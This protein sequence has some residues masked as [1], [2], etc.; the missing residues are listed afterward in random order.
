[1]AIKLSESLSEL[2]MTLVVI[3]VAV[4]GGHVVRAA[5]SLDTRTRDKLPVLLLVRYRV[6]GNASPVY[7]SLKPCVLVTRVVDCPSGAI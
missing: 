1:M 5:L 4:T 7:L 2:K 3:G 6:G